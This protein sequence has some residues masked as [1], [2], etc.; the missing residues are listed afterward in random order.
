MTADDRKKAVLKAL[1]WVGLTDKVSS[2]PAQLSGGECQRVSIAR[3]MVKRPKI[4]IAD[5]PTANLDAANS[6]NILKMMVKLNEELR[7]TLFFASHDEKVIGYLKRIITL[8]DGKVVDDKN[9][10]PQSG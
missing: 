2:R 1:E 3:A 10:A 6:H 4:V 5:E 7:T 8:T 9:I